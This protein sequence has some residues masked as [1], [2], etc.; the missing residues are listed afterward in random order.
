MFIINI[1]V[2]A[3]DVIIVRNFNKYLE[4][5]P[6]NSSETAQHFIKK[7]SFTIFTLFDR[8]LRVIFRTPQVEMKIF[9]MPG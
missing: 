2:E 6:T 5:I 8:A 4:N 3:Y 1:N 9:K 7:A